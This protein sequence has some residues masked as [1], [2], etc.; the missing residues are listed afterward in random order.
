MK[1]LPLSIK[2]PEKLIFNKIRE[3]EFI[4]AFFQYAKLLFT[5]FQVEALLVTKVI[6]VLDPGNLL[7][8]YLRVC[9]F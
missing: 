3:K 5:E 6:T 2:S 7:E 1:C 8:I 9:L 4:N